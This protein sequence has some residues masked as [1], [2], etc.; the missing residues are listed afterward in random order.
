MKNI[1]V[2]VP[3]LKEGGGLT[4]FV[5]HLYTEL[6]NNKSY[7]VVIITEATLPETRIPKFSDKIKIIKA[8]A[9]TKIK[10][11]VTFWNRVAHNSNKYDY[12]HFHTDSLTK[13]YPY[14]VMRN[15][16]NVIVHSH[17]STNERITKNVIKRM[18]H[19]IGKRIV[20]KGKFKKFA[21]SNFAAKWLF[22]DDSYI[23]VNNAID[24]EKFK[25]DKNQRKKIE[26][27]FNLKGKTVYGH[28]GRFLPVK[29]Q[30]RV[31]EIFAKIYS[32]DRDSVLFFFGEGG[33]RTQVE[34]LVKSL[35]LEDVVYFMGFRQDVNRFLNV[36]DWIIFP[37]LYEGLPIT[38]IEA[39]ANGVNVLFSDTITT[40]VK[41]LETS[42]SFSLS[43]DNSVV[44]DRMLHVKLETNK[45]I[46]ACS[47]LKEKGYD[48]N[49]LVQDMHEFYSTYDHA[50]WN[51]KTI[52]EVKEN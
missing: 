30:S 14:F 28:V 9:V 52:Y 41:L 22:N 24:L 40:Q 43:E 50:G 4:E 10:D 8:P 16:E 51:R 1:L 31:V 33:E 6:V 46:L 45:R 32:L 42:K 15:K 17:S 21:C 20:H 23:Q 27:E 48:L 49:D 35:G 12:V 25:F 36:L 34:Y 38:L 26:E 19:K 44:A 47:F 13:F 11:Y 18:L 3:H 29:N 2:I 7:H 5:R 39:Q 37:S